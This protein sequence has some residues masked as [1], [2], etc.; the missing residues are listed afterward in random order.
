[1]SISRLALLALAPSLAAQSDLAFE[2]RTLGEFGVAA[3]DGVSIQTRSLADGVVLPEAETVLDT[4]SDLGPLD[5]LFALHWALARVTPQRNPDGAPGIRWLENANRATASPGFVGSTNASGGLPVPAPAPHTLRLT[6]DAPAGATGEVFIEW[7]GFA[8][9]SID[10]SF[11]VGGDGTIETSTSAPSDYTPSSWTAT[12]PVTATGDGVVVDITKQTLLL[13]P[14]ND[15]YFSFFEAY[16]RPT[17]SATLCTITPGPDACDLSLT[18][19]IGIGATGATE[20]DLVVNGL[21]PQTFGLLLVGTSAPVA[22]VPQGAIC[23]IT[24]EPAAI[25]FWFVDAPTRNWSFPVGNA[26]QFDFRIQA[27]SYRFVT[28]VGPVVQVSDEL[29]VLCQ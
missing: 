19:S 8:G 26:P 14:G 6:V 1:M 22:V 29:G 11:D 7:S 23:P 24:V 3:V 17:G 27:A 4:R 10:L 9:G 5:Q 18:G 16:Y 20:V 2:V 28:G 25:L 21:A 13:G 12:I 15:S